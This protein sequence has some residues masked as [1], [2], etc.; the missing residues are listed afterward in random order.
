MHLN[1][2]TYTHTYSYIVLALIGIIILFVSHIFLLI[3]SC[4]SLAFLLFNSLV[5]L[6]GKLAS[7]SLF[8]LKRERI[9]R[10]RSE[11]ERSWCIGWYIINRINVRMCDNDQLAVLIIPQRRCNIHEFKCSGPETIALVICAH[12]FW[13]LLLFVYFFPLTPCYSNKF[14]IAFST[15]TLIYIHIYTVFIYYI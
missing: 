5:H 14:Y 7:R 4:H 1:T 2:H 8:S 11:T 6:S 9:D 15:C 10:N 13:K 12:R 3:F